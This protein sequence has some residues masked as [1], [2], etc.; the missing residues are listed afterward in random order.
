MP[1]KEGVSALEMSLDD[2]IKQAQKDKRKRKA[3]PGGGATKTVVKKQKTNNN[4]KKNLTSGNGKKPVTTGKKGGALPNIK[5][6]IVNDKAKPAGKT[7]KAAPAKPAPKT[8]ARNTRKN[9]Q[10]VTNGSLFIFFFHFI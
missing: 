1:G 5:V 6:T 7:A 2:R 9:S 10:T 4:N 8:T 3:A